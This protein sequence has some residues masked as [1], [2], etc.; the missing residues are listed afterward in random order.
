MVVTLEEALD[1]DAVV[2]VGY[3]VQKKANLSGAVATVK[4]DEVL[5]D[6]PQPN[7]AAA[8]QGAVP[9][10][11]ISS[12]SGNTPGQTGKAIQIRG[13]ATF[14]GSTTGTSSLS[15]LILIDNVEGDI[16]AL[17]PNDIESVTVLKDA[18]SS[19]IY[20]ARAAAG[21]VLI[22]TKRPK[23]TS[24]SQPTTATTSASS[25]PSAHPSR[26]GWTPTCPSTRRPSTRIPMP[27][28]ARTSTS[29]SNTSTST[30]PTELPSRGWERSRATASSWPTRTASATTSRRR[31]S[32]TA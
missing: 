20:G 10:L 28:Q 6:R 24:A 16:D 27:P 15:P 12:S 21:V 4:M 32:T 1:I 26:H 22:T 5:G 13:S 18:S 29:G 19:A 8:L 30:T 25:T 2:V 3:G 14:S 31:T 9:G 11:M 23:T 17:N 7:V